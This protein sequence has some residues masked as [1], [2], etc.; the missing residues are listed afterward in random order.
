MPSPPLD[1]PGPARG[2]GAA[3]TPAAGPIAAELRRVRARAWRVLVVGAAAILA[4][5]LISALLSVGLLD[6]LLRLPSW[7]RLGLLLCLIAGLV[8]LARRYLLPALGFHPSL[9]DVALRVERTEAAARSG[10]RGVLASGLEF[11]QE[12]RFATPLSG[13]MGFQVSRQ[14]RDR[15][16][17]MPAPALVTYRGTR[18][19]LLALALCILGLL[20]VFA[21]AGPKLTSI[22]LARAVLPWTGAEWPK[23]TELADATQRDVHP[24]GTGLPLRVA[25]TRTDRAPG[26]TP[27]IARYRLLTAGQPGP[28]SRVQLTGQGRLISVPSEKA[29]RE[30]ELYERLI[31]PAALAMTA[32]NAAAE[33]EYWFETR[34]DSTP[35][36][37]VRLVQPPSVVSARA[38]VVP[39]AYASATPAA[40][41]VS[42]E[43]DLGPGSD[44]RAV[45]G[46]VLGGSRVALTLKLSKAVPGPPGQDPETVRAFLADAIP[47][48]EFESL[49]ATFSGDRWVL[50]W[51][52][53]RS[54]R[55]SVQPADEFGIRAPDEAAFSIDVLEDRP[56]SAT[57]VEPREDEAVLA[58]AQVAV[59][60]E[61]R[62]DVG[63]AALA[64]SHQPARAAKGS[65]GAAPEPQEPAVEL[66]ARAFGGDSGPVQAQAALSASL[67]LGAL[68]G[69]ELKPGDE[70]WLF[71]TATD[72][73]DLAGERH[74]PVRSAPRKLRIISAEQ[75]VDQIRSELSALRRAA[76]RLEGDQARAREAVSGGQVSPEDRR[77]QAA[78]T[79]QIGQQVDALQRLQQR[80]RRNNLRDEGIQGLLADLQ[81]LLSEAQGQSDQASAAL[82]SAAQRQADQDRPTSLNQAQQ[83]SIG[84]AQDQVR[85]A[86]AR[87]AEMLDKGED[88]WVLSRTLQRLLEQ[89]RELQARTRQSGERTMGKRADDLTPGER[90]ELEQL[91]EQQQ[92][93]SAAARRALEALS[94]R[95]RQME[96]V[97]ATQAQGMRN[98]ADRGR[99]E[100][101]P[102]KMEQASRD[103][104][105]NQTSSA[106]SEQEEATRALEAMLNDLND[107][108]R[109]RDQALRR[110]LADLMKQ[111]EQLIRD[112]DTQIASLERAR[113][114]SAYDG[115]DRPMMAL[116][117]ATD[118]AAAT[119][120]GDRSTASI[121][122]IIDRASRN[123]SDAI[124]A[125]RGSPVDAEKADQGERESLRLLRLARAEAQK[126]QDAAEK[127]ENDRRKAE[128]RQAYRELLELQVALQGETEPFLGKAPDRRDRLKVRALGERQESL[129]NRLEELKGKTAELA[130]PGVF[131]YAHQR[132]DQSTS[133]AAK[134]LMNAQ[135]DAIVAR[136]QASAVRIL[137][138][139]MDALD[140]RA[141]E[142]DEFREEQDSGGGSG[143]GSG[144]GAKQPLIPPIAELKLLRDMQQEARDMTRAI[145][146]SRES[147]AENEIP[148]L[149]QFQRDLAKRAEEL[150]KKQA[151]QGDPS[152]Q[153]RREPVG[154]GRDPEPKEP[155]RD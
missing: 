89:Q 132:L 136:H 130:E 140:D 116:N 65:I 30:G 117:A 16:S 50:S 90:A 37:R 11:G 99:Q 44:Q 145:D 60:G 21:L 101:V 126:L 22:G 15:F 105:Q 114:E 26:E 45:V 142:E 110:V 8:A 152:G 31:E 40:G 72:T 85:D 84:R 57:I 146:D 106:E 138:A 64:L 94:D 7:I 42:G 53:G 83:E 134:R 27:V 12:P 141:R 91:S 81:G 144:G 58:T 127:A 80:A 9:T 6:Y 147:A 28:T 67:D 78:I 48:A 54:V 149:G 13:L 1:P 95:S 70:V 56:P 121:A 4:S 55:L 17:T 154:Q 137:K 46:P 100:Q 82:E 75:L 119:A 115:L 39:P 102:E 113:E 5:V 63:I 87:M 148:A 135:A 118:T 92:R 68:A 153:P 155:N 18:Q 93:L 38:E 143:S 59:T 35:P 112:Q 103:I 52:A 34:D 62:D 25:L 10:L 108:R 47:G 36:R 20:G 97:D 33:L 129:R 32:P 71:A 122:S 76:M 109:S 104:N 96:K 128:L 124:S 2:G 120:R 111:L 3:A 61:G 51:S 24:L 23:R 131:E 69:A 74:A 73:Y 107:A 151:Q 139:L 19:S 77:A 86:L 125:L 88:G 49:A 66:A 43:R 79:Q 123:Q 29:P 98:A 150:L 14:A 133:V 41:F